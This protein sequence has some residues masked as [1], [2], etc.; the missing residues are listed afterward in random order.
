[1]LPHQLYNVVE[2]GRY[3][4]VRP[5]PRVV[6]AVAGQPLPVRAEGIAGAPDGDREARPAA[7]QLGS[8]VPATRVHGLRCGA[9]IGCEA[10]QWCRWPVAPVGLDMGPF[11]PHLGLGGSAICSNK[12]SSA[13]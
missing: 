1:V 8:V 13:R 10:R 3:E 12:T 7:V 2:S 5:F 4:S 9:D 11:G 6:T